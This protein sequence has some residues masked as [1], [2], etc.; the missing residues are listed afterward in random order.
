VAAAPGNPRSALEILQHAQEEIDAVV[1]GPSPQA[2]VAAAPPPPPAATQTETSPLLKLYTSASSAVE[3]VRA[4]GSSRA[5]SA[6]GPGTATTA[7]THNIA[8]AAQADNSLLR[9]RLAHAVEELADAMMRDGDDRREASTPRS[10][11][12]GGGGSDGASSAQLRQQLL[13]DMDADCERLDALQSSA[14]GGSRR[15]AVRA[16]ARRRRGSP[17]SP[18]THSSSEAARRRREPSPTPNNESIRRLLTTLND[19]LAPP[20]PVAATLK[21]AIGAG[22]RGAPTTGHAPTPTAAAMYRA[23]Q[24]WEDRASRLDA[25]NQALRKSLVRLDRAHRTSVTQRDSLFASDVSRLIMEKEELAEL[26][27]ELARDLVVAR[28]PP[29]QRAASPQQQAV[30]TSASTARATEA[31]LSPMSD[32]TENTSS[33]QPLTRG[34]IERLRERGWA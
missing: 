21:D 34:E 7:T 11:P 27:T 30:P 2:S 25:E 12:Q 28:S 19:H 22:R 26:L 6:S 9:T 29:Q 16:A 4:G 32:A 17:T 14:G 8:E 1:R 23:A 33:T 15:T 10:S 20:P 24:D 31:V 18:T 5:V 3:A 13:R